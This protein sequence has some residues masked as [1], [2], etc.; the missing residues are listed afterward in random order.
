M[1]EIDGS[2][3]EGGGQILR[4][5]LALSSIMGKPFRIGNIR[6]GRKKPGLMAQHLSAVNAARAV[7][8]ATVS[9][10]EK[11]STELAFTPGIVRGGDFTLDIGTAGSASLVLQTVIPPLLLAP[12]KSRITIR[13]GTHVPFSPVVD[14]I[15]EIFAPA[16]ARLGGEIRLRVSSYGFYPRGGGEVTAEITPTQGLQPIILAGP[17]RIERITGR[18]A[19]GNLPLSIAERQRAAAS[20][21]I[22]EHLPHADFPVDVEASTVP[23][24]GKGTFIFLKTEMEG[25]FAGF[26]ALGEIGKRAEAVGEQAARAL[27]NFHVSGAAVDPHL[28]DQLVPYLALAGGTSSFTTSSITLHLLTNLWVVEQFLPIRSRITGKM[29]EPGEV[30]ISHP[31]LAPPA[32][33]P[34]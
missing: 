8:G 7:T 30:V 1:L 25:G 28:A 21:Y 32:D 9:G 17:A 18:S 26:A 27:V 6:M 4:T 23:A 33:S 14:Y 15:A 2:H 22:R 3:G 34:E 12:Q 29:G 24:P 31:P 20:D 5:A 16:L 11:G 10:G 19:V 13:G